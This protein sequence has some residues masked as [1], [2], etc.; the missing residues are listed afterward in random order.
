[1]NVNPQ[2]EVDPSV[3]SSSGA[4]GSGPFLGRFGGKRGKGEMLSLK[5]NLKTKQEEDYLGALA[6]VMLFRTPTL[7]KFLDLSECYV[8]HL[9]SEGIP[10]LPSRLPTMHTH[11][12]RK[13]VGG[14]GYVLKQDINF[15]FYSSATIHPLFEPPS[16]VGWLT[17]KP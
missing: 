5:Y 2:G 11:T 9:N 6:S 4:S 3:P 15:Q 13:A 14:G 7:D 16:R 17:G 8:P 12:L 1:M 10:N